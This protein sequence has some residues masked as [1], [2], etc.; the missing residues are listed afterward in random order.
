[1]A[2]DL[3]CIIQQVVKVIWHKTALPLQTDADGSVVFARWC[4]CAHPYGHIGAT[5]QIWLNLCFLRPT[6]VHN[7]NG[8]SISVQPFLHSSRQTVVGYIGA[9]WWIRLKLC[10]LAPSGKYG[11]IR[12]SFG[13]PKCTTQT[14][15][16]SVQQFLHSSRQKIPIL[17]NGRPFAPK[18]ALLM[19]DLDP[20]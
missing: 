15:N 9:T 1:M 17:Y 4:H 19:G 2:L 13:S 11:W 8:K 7:P 3:I 20:I 5:C 12:A 10:T 18:L 16:R 6:L 14:A